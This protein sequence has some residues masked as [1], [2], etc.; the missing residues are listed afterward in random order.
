MASSPSYNPNLVETRFTKISTITADCRPAAPLVNRASQGLYPPGSTF[1]VVTTAAALALGRFAP[2]S[3]FVDPGYCIAYGKRVNNFDTSSPFG[4]LT[5]AEALK[6][7]VN[8]VF[9]NMGKALGAKA[10]LDQAKKFGFYETCCSRR[11][12]GSATPAGSTGTASSGIR[13]ATRTSTRVEWR[14]DR[15]ACS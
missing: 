1:K 5:L 4:R 9:C 11:P 7:S 14:S 6:H 12:T 8:S 2:D 15:S 13:S 3:E 10:I